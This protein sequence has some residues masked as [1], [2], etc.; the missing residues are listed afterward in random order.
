MDQDWDTIL[1]QTIP[2]IV[3]AE[4]EL[5]Y[6]L[7]M[8]IFTAKI[9]DSHA[10]FYS[11]TFFDWR[12][13]DYAPFLAKFI[14]NKVVITKVHSNFSEIL[15]K[16]DII[17]KIDGF[18]I[19][20]LIDSLRKFSHGSNEISIMKN[21]INLILWGDALPFSLTVLNETGEHTVNLFRGY[22][23]T[24]LYKDNTPYWR[25]VTFNGCRFG[26]VHMGNLYDK[27]IPK[28]IENFNHVDA[29][30]FDIRNYPNETL[31]TLVDYLFDNPI[32]IVNFTRS[33]VEYPGVFFWD[34]EWIGEGTLNPVRKKTMILFN[35]ETISQ[36]EYTC[37]GLEQI[38][39]SLKIG[40]TTAAA[41]GNISYIY[42]PGKIKTMVTF[43]GVYYPDYTPTQRVGIIPDYYVHPTIQGIRE[44]RD[45]VLEFALGLELLNCEFGIDDVSINKEIRIYPNPTSGELRI[46]MSDMRYVI[47][48]IE[49]SDVFG[50]KQKGENRRQKAER[51]IVLD[52]SALQAGFYFVKITTE[53]GT[54]IR[55]VVKY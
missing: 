26:I 14:E 47:C 43:L 51:E 16:G 20:Y 6:H 36:A 33:N 22:Y 8:R 15:R 4:N 45:E 42:L 40:S 12:G 11:T 7:A 19:D 30:I 35:E 24:A 44:G 28:L 27:H 34:K 10:F 13:Q 39:G 38:P 9:N 54:L 17:T 2:E 31:W 46:E 55:K 3:E 53:N 41:D 23:N 32:H 25:E 21:L 5:E 48:D 18:D 37:M 52:I 1:L 29:I 49:I 50:R